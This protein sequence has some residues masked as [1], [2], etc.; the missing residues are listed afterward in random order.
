VRIQ[1]EIQ[2][3]SNPSGITLD[4][5]GRTNGDG[6]AEDENKFAPGDS[7][8]KIIRLNLKEEGNHVLAVTVTYTETTFG[9]GGTPTKSTGG[10]LLEVGGQQHLSAQGARVRTFRKLYQFVAQNLVGVRTKAGD[11]PMSRGGKRRF[12]VEAQ[13][14]NMGER[15]VSLEVSYCSILLRL[16]PLAL[17]PPTNANIMLLGRV[18]GTTTTIQVDVS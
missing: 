9:A 7:V 12:A 8:Q 3:P 6:E 5:E 13:L 4:L 18:D 17:C 16:L 11:L 2:T 1:A 15:V 10:P 14:E